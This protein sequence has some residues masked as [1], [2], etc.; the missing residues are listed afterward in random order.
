MSK[1]YKIL[2]SDIG[3][4]LLSNGW[5]HESRMAG[6][7]KFGI[8]FDEMEVLHH[9]IFNVY[10]IGKISLDGYLD[11]VVFNKKRDFSREEFRQF[12][13]DQ[14]VLLPKML[15]WLIELKNKHPYLK[16]ISINNEAR[17]L[18]QHRIR[19]FN[20]HDFFDAFVSSC[21]VGMRKPDPG[22]FQIALGIAQAE[23]KECLYLDDRV[24]LVKAARQSGI[25]AYHHTDFETTKNLLEQ[26]LS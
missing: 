19:K 11:T 21:E 13:L 18:N 4:V 14:S 1:K 9:F 26:K 2:F 22:I 12:I 8:N 16:V 10:E 25:D 20:L 5:G 7:K 3:G 23:P 15:P 17:E 6:A 24:M